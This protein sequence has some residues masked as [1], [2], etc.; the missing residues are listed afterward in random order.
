MK[1]A[2]PNRLPLPNPMPKP[3]RDAPLDRP[4]D[5]LDAVRA[6]PA[7]GTITKTSPVPRWI[8]K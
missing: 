6:G 2:L 4:D 5:E 7:Y 8:E 1:P 3:L